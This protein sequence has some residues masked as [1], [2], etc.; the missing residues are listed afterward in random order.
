MSDTYQKRQLLLTFSHPKKYE[1]DLE[2][3]KKIYSSQLI[4]FFIFQNVIDSNNLYITYNIDPTKDASKYPS[5][6]SIHRKQ[7]TCTLFTINALNKLIAEENGGIFDKNV[8]LNWDL[9]KNCI[10][11][12][13]ETSVRIIDVKLLDIIN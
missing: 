3:I 2:G 8:K 13:G 6:I 10:I 1:V 11:L 7:E 5:T 4:K 9:Y 12:T